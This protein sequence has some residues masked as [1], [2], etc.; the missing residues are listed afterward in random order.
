MKHEFDI[1]Y[2]LHEIR[3]LLKKQNEI[4]EKQ[5]QPQTK[6]TVVGNKAQANTPKGLKSDE[7]FTL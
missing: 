3:D 1:L 2:T 7:D 5:Q 4:L 6:I